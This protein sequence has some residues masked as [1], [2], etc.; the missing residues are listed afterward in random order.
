MGDSG[1]SRII[2]GLKLSVALMVSARAVAMV[3]YVKPA[4]LEV[5][6][7]RAAQWSREQSIMYLLGGSSSISI[8]GGACGMVELRGSCSLGDFVVSNRPGFTGW[9]SI[10]D[11]ITSTS[12]M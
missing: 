1:I 10:K 5:C 2:Y 3:V 4:V 6:L 9:L 7:H 12:N 11:D 8:L